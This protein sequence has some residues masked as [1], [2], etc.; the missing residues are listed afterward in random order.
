MGESGGVKLAY[1]WCRAEMDAIGYPEPWATLACLMYAVTSR[2]LH[3]G[4]AA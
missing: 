1:R 4:A 2:R 3:R